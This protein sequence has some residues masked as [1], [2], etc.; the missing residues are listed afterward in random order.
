M[1]TA[2]ILAA[3]M[4]VGP[5]PEASSELGVP[6]ELAELRRRMKAKTAAENEPETDRLSQCLTRADDDSTAVVMEAGSWLSKASGTERAEALHCRG[7]AEAVLGQWRAA[8]ASFADARAMLPENDARYRA[9]L[10][11]MA[12]NALISDGELLPALTTLDTAQK[13]AAAA[14]F[15]ALGGEIAL[16]RARVLVALGDTDQAS[17]AL[18]DA[19]RLIPLS[20]RAWLL[21]ATLARR[22]EQLEDAQSYITQ[23]RTLDPTNPEILLEAG[24]VAVLTGDD[25]AARGF[26]EAVLAA[27]G[28]GAQAAIARDYLGQLAE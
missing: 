16:D 12:G 10:G 19:R 18:A 24:V 1:I 20:A 22:V 28:N 26:W 27:P 25:D 5:N 17:Q 3:L 11:A 4:Q 14:E 8:A 23:A 2:T 15:P 9:R 6:E 7:Y 13:D 21:S